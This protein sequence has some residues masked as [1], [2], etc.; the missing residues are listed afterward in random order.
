MKKNVLTAI[1]LCF[2]GVLQIALAQTNVTGHVT[3]SLTGE[4]LVGANIREIGGKGSA[5]TNDSGAFSISVSG[6]NSS[7]QVTYIGYQSQQVSV[8][9]QATVH[10]SL[11]RIGDALDEVV[12]VGYGTRRKSQLTGAISS[13]SSAEL[14]ETPVVFIDQALQGRAAG[15]DVV[16][17]GHRPGEGATVRI[18]G[19]NSISAGN[20]PL[21]VVDGI[22]VSRGVNLINPNFI[23]SI[24]VLK[25]ASATAIYGSR[26]SNGVILITTKQGKAGRTQ[27]SYESYAGFS[28]ILNKVDVLDG[29]EWVRYKEASRRTDD[30]TVLLD[31]IELAN[32]NAGIEVDWVDLNLRDG[33]Q[34]SHSLSSSGGNEKT[35]F[36]VDVNFLKQNGI[37]YNSDFTRG[38]L[39]FNVNHKVNERFNFGLTT[40]LFMSKTNLINAGAVLSQAMQ[41]SPLGDIYEDDGRYRLFPT[42]E[43]LIGNPLANVDNERNQQIRNRM[44]SSLFAEYQIIEGLKYRLNFGP[45][46]TFS[47]DGNFIGSYTTILQGAPNRASNSRDD[48]KAY[49]LENLLMYNREFG[50]GHEIDLTLLQSIQEEITESN[51]VSAMGMPSEKMLWHKLSAGEI[52]SYDSDQQGWSLL[53]Y[54]ARLN[55]A[56]KGKYMLTLTARRDGSS[57]F[58]DDRK[59][60]F[61]PAFAMGWNIKQENFMSDVS[62]LTELK[63]RASHGS[64]G[65]TAINPYQSLGAVSRSGYVF[66]DE[67]ALGFRPSTLPNP[68]LRWEKSTTTNI[69]LDFGLFNNRLTGALE[70]YVVNTTDLLLNQSVPRLSGYSSILVNI[71]KTRNVGYEA[72]ISSTNVDAGGF[73]WVTNL[74]L[75]ANQNK[76]VDLYGNE[77][78]DIGNSRFIGKPISVFYDLAFDGIWQE[79]EAEIAESYGRIPG[80]IKVKDTNNDSQINAEDRVI[81]GSPFPK[82]QGGLTNYFSY[83]GIDLSVF[84]HTRQGFML[85]SS[86]HT[87]DNL[88]GRYNIPRFVNYYTPDNPSNEFPRPVNQG[89]T[90]VNM[91]VLRY[92]DGSFVRVKNISLG[93]T[94][95]A[96]SLAALRLQ[97]L[98]VYLNA[99]NPF[100]FT[101]YEGWD[102]EAGSNVDSYPSTKTFLAGL[103][104]N[105]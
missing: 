57:R 50:N 83:K 68:D 55:Y 42:N 69:G 24:E 73:K 9:G 25:D 13:I 101:S 64:V 22:P 7:L 102:P 95:N 80:Q 84:I 4:P 46:L 49:T 62:G 14:K 48:T 43:A 92:R 75:G 47:N 71:G 60:G 53:S 99:F 15:V 31:P 93:Y 11:V 36:S 17:A 78:D 87:I 27:F 19:V 77:A 32:Y 6:A 34:H 88:A 90:N 39:Q 66:G 59:F 8:A 16:S 96:K 105:F 70:Y 37:V 91:G 65:N 97:S 10:I 85:N 86:L 29:E 2:L 12:V 18:R 103:S 51:T 76:I 52:R 30:L 72:S 67:T 26:G 1:F 38:S 74:N 21:Y 98:R 40:L 79:H 54:M 3:D 81:L 44:F 28:R 89:Q 104:V 35:K 61:F 82:W 100:T 5:T 58:G 94:F 56:Y 45:D 23:E 33:L 41:I 20:D 63:L